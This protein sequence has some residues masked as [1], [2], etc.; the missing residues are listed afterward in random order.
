MP[1][2]VPS[3]VKTHLLHLSK[4][5]RSRMLAVA[6][7]SDRRGLTPGKPERHATAQHSANPVWL[8]P[9]DA[10][11]RRL[12]LAAS[13]ARR[14][15]RVCLRAFGNADPHRRERR[16]HIARRLHR[17][18]FH[19]PDAV[20]RH[21]NLLDT[22]AIVS[23]C[24]GTRNCTG[25]ET[26]G[27]PSGRR[28]RRGR[29]IGHERFRRDARQ[30]HRINERPRRD[31]PGLSYIQCR[32]LSS[33]AAAGTRGFRTARRAC[34][35]GT[36]RRR[37]T[38]ARLRGVR[39]PAAGWR[40]IGCAVA[41]GAGRC[42]TGSMRGS[43]FFLRPNSP[44]KRRSG[45][46]CGAGARSGS[47][48]CAGAARRIGAGAG[49]SSSIAGASSPPRI[50]ASAGRCGAGR[51]LRTQFVGDGLVLAMH[52]VGVAGRAL[53]LDAWFGLGLRLATPPA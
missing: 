45:S 1:T 32:T 4:A 42:C 10:R 7:R 48:R 28:L 2:L 26:V 39:R 52:R 53:R 18:G 50:I 38:A 5:Y 46:G 6:I 33:T 35:R 37:A 14:R 12:F 23:R 49:I 21:R 34:D 8:E 29:P 13:L 41:R 17:Q 25:R 9:R 11:S 47:M 43:S 19:P 27:P 22:K 31:G 30:S 3:E 15:R 44:R 40:T 24:P 51:H 36:D 20:T 16:A